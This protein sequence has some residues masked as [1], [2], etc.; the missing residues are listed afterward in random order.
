M[1]RSRGTSGR[2]APAVGAG[3]CVVGGGAEG[4]PPSVIS[5]VAS[6]VSALS[7]GVQVSGTT[8]GSVGVPSAR[9]GVRS[10]VSR[11]AVKVRPPVSPAVT[12][13]TSPD[14]LSA[15]SPLSGTG[16]GCA[17]VP[18][19]TAS[20]VRS[21]WA[22]ATVSRLAPVTS[23]ARRRASSPRVASGRTTVVET[24]SAWTASLT[25]RASGRVAAIRTCIR[26][27]S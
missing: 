14:V 8:A 23:A 15:I 27:A 16:T 9:R 24:P 7:S 10:T 17:A 3:C 1:P 13:G 22:T 20:A 6:S 25:E 18:A 26:T 11:P 12:V 5:T 2:G 19:Q 21:S 4:L